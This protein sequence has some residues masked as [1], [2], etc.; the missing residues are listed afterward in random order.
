MVNIERSICALDCRLDQFLR[1]ALV[2]SSAEFDVC[3]GDAANAIAVKV[4]V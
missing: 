1:N 3:N 2:I 4:S